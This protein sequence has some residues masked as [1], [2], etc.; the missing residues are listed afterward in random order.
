MNVQKCEVLA[1]CNCLI[2][3]LI[4]YLVSVIFTVTLFSAAP[5]N[6]TLNF[7]VLNTSTHSITVRLTVSDCNGSIPMY[8][9]QVMPSGTVTE[10]G[11]MTSTVFE[12]SSLSPA[13]AY[14]VQ[15]VDTECPNVILRRFSVMTNASRGELYL[16]TVVF[17]CFIQSH[18]VE[19]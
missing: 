3:V 13:T 4:L 14:D 2:F 1:M 19:I 9:V 15:L 12:I 11:Q 8:T 18:T 6:C 5:T 10:T 7:N 17:V 16:I